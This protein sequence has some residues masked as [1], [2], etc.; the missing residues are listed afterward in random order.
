M[1]FYSSADAI[2]KLLYK[3]VDDKNKPFMMIALN[4]K[5]IV[6][7]L[8]AERSKVKKLKKNILF[9]ATNNNVWMQEL[10]LRKNIIIKEIKHKLDIELSD[11]VF[12]TNI[13]N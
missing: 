11:I 5:N 13:E 10:A 7:D 9:I 4:W 8:L 6:G 12:F 3:I 1:R 2:K